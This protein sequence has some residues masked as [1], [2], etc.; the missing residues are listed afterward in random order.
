MLTV[1]MLHGAHVDVIEQAA[2]SLLEK[3]GQPEAALSWSALRS[4]T[5]SAA[6]MP[7]ATMRAASDS[8]CWGSI[9]RSGHISGR[10]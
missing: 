5:G 9:R 4:R 7:R 3:A 10:T 2:M 6:S 1:A 8:R